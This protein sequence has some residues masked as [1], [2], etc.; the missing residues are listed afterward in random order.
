MGVI[1]D[2]MLDSLIH[3]QNNQRPNSR[4]PIQRQIILGRGERLGTSRTA[5][6]KDRDAAFIDLGVEPEPRISADL[7]FFENL[8]KVY[9]LKQSFS[10]L[11]DSIKADDVPSKFMTVV[12]DEFVSCAGRVWKHDFCTFKLSGSSL[13][14]TD[15]KTASGDPGDQSDLDFCFDASRDITPEEWNQFAEEMNR[16]RYFYEDPEGLKGSKAIRLRDR[17]YNRRWEIVPVAV[18]FT[19][20]NVRWGRKSRLQVDKE[21]SRFFSSNPGAKRSTRVLKRMLPYF[22]GC[23]ITV[24]VVKHGESGKYRADDSGFDLFAQILLQ[25][26]QY[27][28]LALDSPIQALLRDVEAQGGDR[29]KSFKDNLNAAQRLAKIILELLA[30]ERR[31]E[32]DIRSE[33]KDIA[34]YAQPFQQMEEGDLGHKMNPWAR[35]W[36]KFLDLGFAQEFQDRALTLVSNIERGCEE[37][38]F[39]TANGK[40]RKLQLILFQSFYND[41][42]KMW[43]RSIG[44][45]KKCIPVWP[46]EDGS[47]ELDYFLMAEAVG[48][49][50]VDKAREISANMS[51]RD[52]VVRMKTFL[53]KLIDE[54]QQPHKDWESVR[55]EADVLAVQIWKQLGSGPSLDR[56][57][58]IHPGQKPNAWGFLADYLNFL[59]MRGVVHQSDLAKE[60][61]DAFPTEDNSCRIAYLYSEP[62]SSVQKLKAIYEDERVGFDLSAR[63]ELAALKC[64]LALHQAGGTCAVTGCDLAEADPLKL[65]KKWSEL[66]Y[67][68]KLYNKSIMDKAAMRGQMQRL[69]RSG[70]QLSSLDAWDFNARCKWRLQTLQ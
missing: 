10:N 41:D 7:D 57:Q 2:L 36:T 60:V 38:E 31:G 48:L 62:A 47:F 63:A 15:I 3:N 45:A 55:H 61:Q 66:T 24:L 46:F 50:Q 22:P 26:K 8:T 27:P 42:R 32:Q 37:D 33:L 51:S 28:N 23:D 4:P 52:L 6:S 19:Y 43:L 56:T 39:S 29:A 64:Q 1:L 25:L 40:I 68:E 49:G 35:M 69:L 44:A 53:M 11:A 18:H 17:I 30:K 5:S 21:W 16:S 14:G 65:I 67:A 20:D 70:W 9:G 54:G 12:V 59:W 13:F 34:T 58:R